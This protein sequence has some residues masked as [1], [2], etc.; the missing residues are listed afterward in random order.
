[1]SRVALMHL[2]PRD[3]NDGP[4]REFAL[5]AGAATVVVAAHI[6][7]AASIMALQTKPES[8]GAPDTA[9]MVD[10]AP[11][12]T[13]ID[14]PQVDQPADMEA[15]QQLEEPQAEPLEEPEVA[16]TLKPPPL[17]PLPEPVIDMPE[18]DV[19]PAKPEAVLPV[20]K[21]KKPEPKPE[22][23]KP[24]KVREQPERKK[25]VRK[26]KSEVSS[27]RSAT[28]APRA[29][30][31]EAKEASSSVSNANAMAAWQNRVS[32]RVA[33]F[34]RADSGIG[35]VRVQ[36]VVDANGNVRSSSANS[37][38][39]ILDRAALDMVR[40]ANPLPAPPPESGMANK[41]FVLP[42]FFQR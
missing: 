22:Q 2:P 36:L 23:K 6:G 40:R 18:P 19:A 42:V 38:N 30:R 26:P 29:E 14:A 39:P 34:K 16:E 24:E 27:Q 28:D 35:T 17:E 41:P 37:G 12:T 31:S 25:V 7:I 15:E 8:S 13:S 5:W 11:M 33:R 32:A 4:L 3:D 20:E 21:P 10:L 1:M 9:I